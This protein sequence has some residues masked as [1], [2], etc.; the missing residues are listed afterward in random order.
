M[1]YDVIG[2]IHGHADKL[3]A[4]LGKLGYRNQQ[5]TWRHPE[6]A[7]TAIFVGDF[8]D[9]GPGQLETIGIVRSM[10]DAGTAQA[11][12]GNH[13]FNAVAWHTPDLQRPGQ[14]LRKRSDKNLQ[15]HEAFLTETEHDPALHQ[16]MVDWFLTLPVWLDLPGLRIVHA[17]WDP[18][19]IAALAPRLLPGNKLDLAL[20]HAASRAGTMEFDAIETLLKG[21]EIDLPAGYDFTDPGGHVRNRVRLRWWD[22]SAQTYRQ[23]GIANGAST[24]QFPELPLPDDCVR[25]YT[26]DTPVLFG[27]Y[28]ESGTPRPHSPKV[29]CVDYSACKGGPLVAYCWQ[30]ETEL[31]ESHF[32]GTDH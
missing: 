13:E 25:G 6:P 32:V 26:D 18:K 15:Q 23:A 4:L 8:I 1:Q 11:V 31:H 17:C 29:A 28:W 10:L 7:R 2:D 5:G 12:M 27:H 16:E 22:G 19:H 9:R 21:P 30:G 3:V 14:H 24:Q 20:V